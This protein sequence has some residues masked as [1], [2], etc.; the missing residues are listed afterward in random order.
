MNYDVII[1][2][3][4]VAGLAA[5]EKLRAGGITNVLVVDA[6]DYVGGRIKTWYG[7]GYPIEIGAEFIHGDRTV[8]WEYVRELGMATIRADGAVRLIDKNGHSMS[9]GQRQEYESIMES[10]ASSAANGVSVAE[11]IAS[12]KDTAPIVRQLA[13]VSVGDYEAGDAAQLDSG[14]FADMLR[15]T[16]D[17]GENYI[18]VGGYQPIVKRLAKG[19]IIRL[20]AVVTEVEYS[21]DGVKITLADGEVLSAKRCIVTVSLGVLKAGDIRFTPALPQSFQQAVA[22][23]GMGNAMKLII[24]F[25]NPNIARQLFNYADGE[26]AALQTITNWWSSAAD[27]HVLVGYCGGSRAAAVLSMKPSDLIAKIAD[28][29]GEIMGR[30]LRDDIADYK[31]ARWDNNPFTKGAYSNH[32]VGVSLSDRAILAQPVANRLFFAGEATAE[33]GNYATVHGAIETGRRAAEAVKN[34]LLS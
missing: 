12:Q 31:I 21:D 1:I 7:W 14:S 20:Q 33:N 3:A 23:L 24:R 32:P 19:S 5:A 4:G 8:S 16:K 18:P 34:S 26:S 29:L 27:P 30:N 11:H 15:L 10:L 6:Q 28:D 22:K 17:N 2:G 13:E 25:K 9:A